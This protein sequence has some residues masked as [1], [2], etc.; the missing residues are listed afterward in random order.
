MQ[1]NIASQKF[2]VFAFDATTNL[3]IL[4]DAA[5]ITAT[6]SKDFAADSATNDVNP[7]ETQGGFYAFDATQAE[8]NANDI[9]IFPSSVTANIQVI[10]VPGLITTVPVNF[11][12]DI[13]QTADHTAGIADI[14]TTA[15]FNARTIAS[16]N[17]ATASALATVDSVVDAILVDTNELQLNQG[18]WLTAT[19]FATTAE[20]ADVPTVAEF[21]ARTIPSANY[22]D[23]AVDSV[24]NVTLV[25][26]TT[27]NTDMRGTDSANTVIPPSVAQFN[28]RSIPSAD[29][30]IVTDYTAPDNT[31]IAQIQV[32]IAALNDISVSDI[33]T[34]QMTESYAGDGVAPTLAQSLFLTMQNLQ[35]FSFTGVT[36]TVKKLD[37][38]SVAATY[39]LDDALTP[40]SKTRAT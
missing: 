29:Y 34:T 7:T 14:P 4:G 27:T 38:T 32:D 24:A 16:A 19:G 30:F 9:Q 10:S 33:L 23:P 2:I 5:N 26:T 20:I 40:T 15:E 8:T 35:D 11:G 25:D 31:G 22:F 12:D 39:T 36:Q 3:P 37:G 21:N 28:A 1:K 13:I 18:D 6:I 17:Y